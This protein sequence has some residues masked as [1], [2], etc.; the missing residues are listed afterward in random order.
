[1]YAPDPKSELFSPLLWP[2]G[3]G[4]LPKTFLQISGLD[5]LRDDGLIYARELDNAGVDVKINT[6]LGVPHGF[7]AI[8][9]SLDIAAKASEEQDVGFKWLFG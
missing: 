4:G 1:H 5:P 6:Y 9:G 7:E 2:S 3:H 8:F